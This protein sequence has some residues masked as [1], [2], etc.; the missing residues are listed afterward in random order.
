VALKYGYESP[1]AFTKAFQRLHGVTPSAAK[2]SD[3][4]LKAFARISFQIQIKGECEMNYR[5]VEEGAYTVVGKDFVIQADP[6]KEIP[7]FVETIW[8][9]GTHD[10]INEAASRPKGSLLF[11]YYYDFNESSSNRY[12]MGCEVPEEHNFSPELTTLRV[13]A[14]TYAVFEGREA[15]LEDVEIGLEIQNVWRRIYSE[16]FPSVHFEQIEGPSV[17]KYFWVDDQREESICEVWVPVQR[18]S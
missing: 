5:I 7:E 15:M 9:D 2:K 16:W 11:G 12:L 4:R 3:V 1:E 10:R 17:E 14:Q 8:K 13:P 6:Y 18:K